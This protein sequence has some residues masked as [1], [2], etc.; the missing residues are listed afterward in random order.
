MRNYFGIVGVQPDAIQHDVGRI[1]FRLA[2]YYCES[3][4]SEPDSPVAA[5]RYF[6]SNNGEVNGPFDLDMIE[7]LILSAVQKEWTTE[8]F[9]GFI[10]SR[11]HR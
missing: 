7:A 2:G 6:V 11:F 9:A 5:L 3:N 4:V 1:G 8:I 10:W